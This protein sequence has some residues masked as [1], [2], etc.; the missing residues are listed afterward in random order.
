MKSRQRKNILLLSVKK[1]R[2]VVVVMKFYL[3]MYTFS[4]VLDMLSK[5]FPKDQVHVLL[6]KFWKCHS[7]LAVCSVHCSKHE[8]LFLSP[9]FYTFICSHFIATFSSSQHIQHHS[10]VVSIG[11]KQATEMKDATLQTVSFDSLS[12]V[13][14]APRQK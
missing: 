2:V 1:L 8:L 4:S 11:I 13:S 7:I 9:A 10:S 14:L 12:M 6:R 5:I 3:C